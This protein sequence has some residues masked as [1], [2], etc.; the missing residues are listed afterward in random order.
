MFIL[1][2]PDV[3]DPIRKVLVVSAIT[4]DHHILESGK[5]DAIVA[6]QRPNLRDIV[7]QPCALGT[8]PFI[9]E[10][11]LMIPLLASRRQ[12]DIVLEHFGPAVKYGSDL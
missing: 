1:N 2:D 4:A 3:L 8:E 9:K 10:R 5:M 6:H 12:D 11:A 7:F